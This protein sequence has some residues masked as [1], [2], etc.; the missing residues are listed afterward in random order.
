[1]ETNHWKSP[2][3]YI[4]DYTIM[5]I[6]N[7]HNMRYFKKV[8]FIKLFQ[9]STLRSYHQTYGCM[10]WKRGAELSPD[11]HLVIWIKWLGTVLDWPCP[12]KWVV[13]VNRDQLVVVFSTST[14]RRSF[15]TSRRRMRTWNQK[16]LL[17][18]VVRR[19]MWSVVGATKEAV[20]PFL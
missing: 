10:F 1:M 5:W 11:H 9:W 20:D 16:R 3:D 2:A 14:T 7:I 8:L 12:A 4:Y 15:H 13:R 18:A 6:F 17:S 19:S